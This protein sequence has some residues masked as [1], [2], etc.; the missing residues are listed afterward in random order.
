MTDLAERIVKLEQELSKTKQR[1]IRICEELQKSKDQNL[2][3]EIK[4][5][6]KELIIAN[7]ALLTCQSEKEQI[8]QDLNSEIEKVKNSNLSNEEKSKQ[9]ITL[10][11]N[12]QQQ[13]TTACQHLHS[14]WQ[15]YH[16]I[17]QKVIESLESKSHGETAAIKRLENTKQNQ[18][19]VNGVLFGNNHLFFAHSLFKKRPKVDSKI[20][21]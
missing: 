20:K 5:K 21:N 3:T 10:T 1:L 15:F 19:V 13:F 2:L 4:I 17:Q 12:N 18:F 7:D 8:L 9:I 11:T 16:Q 6:E 14:A